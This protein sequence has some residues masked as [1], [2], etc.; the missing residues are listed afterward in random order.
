MKKKIAEQAKITSANTLKALSGF[1][2]T[3][4]TKPNSNLDWI[5]IVSKKGET[6][7]DHILRHALPNCNHKSHGVFNG[8]PITMV[9]IA[10]AHRR[11]ISPTSDGMGCTI[12][13]IPYKNAGYESGYI[14]TG[15]TLD[16]ITIITVENSLALITAFPSLGDY[17]NSDNF[18]I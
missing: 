10:W 11:L 5:T 12:Y 8:N 6:R 16:Y 1:S 15:A 4:Y 17:Q 18:N 7:T 9:N 14:N 3:I 2:K 13:N